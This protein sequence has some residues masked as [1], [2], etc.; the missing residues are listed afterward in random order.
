MPK[1][2]PT[3]CQ[4]YQQ[5][6]N[7]IQEIIGKQTFILL[8]RKG[9]LVELNKTA[10]FILKKLEKPL[11]IKQLAKLLSKKFAVGFAKAEK[12]VRA[13]VQKLTKLKLI[14]SVP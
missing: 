1:L 6:P 9:K 2:N 10:S 4:K 8:P 3:N 5:V 14:K 12:D 11:D 13:A 7:I